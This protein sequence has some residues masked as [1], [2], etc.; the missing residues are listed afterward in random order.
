M[1]SAGYL[2]AIIFKFPSGL[3]ARKRDRSYY[4]ACGRLTDAISLVILPLTPRRIELQALPRADSYMGRGAGQVFGKEEEQSTSTLP[5]RHPQLAAEDGRRPTPATSSVGSVFLDSQGD[6]TTVVHDRSYP[7]VGSPATDACFTTPPYAK[8]CAAEPLRNGSLS[9]LK[10]ACEQLERGDA[11]NPDNM[12][13]NRCDAQLVESYSIC[14]RK[15]RKWG[16]SR[17]N[18]GGAHIGTHSR[19]PL[20]LHM[21]TRA[22]LSPSVLVRVSPSHGT[23]RCSRRRLHY[24]SRVPPR[25][26]PH[27]ASLEVAEPPRLHCCVYVYGLRCRIGRR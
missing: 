2:S 19:R 11:W 4:T 6:G 23:S 22:Q 25:F 21:R 13:G 10:M 3:K 17:L 26:Y 27:V 15:S 1:F 14:A 7:G 9:Q 24:A 8:Q 18:R 20:G 12:S 5:F 16:V